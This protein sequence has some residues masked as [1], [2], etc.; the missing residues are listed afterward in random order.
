MT[1]MYYWQMTSI[2]LINVTMKSLRAIVDVNQEFTVTA[3]ISK[4]SMTERRRRCRM[5]RDTK[6]ALE[7]TS[8]DT[9]ILDYNI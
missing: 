1:N 2:H 3:S 4:Q 9:N 8:L 7:R 6:T 5:I